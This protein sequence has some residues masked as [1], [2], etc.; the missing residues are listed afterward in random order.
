M[1][2]IETATIGPSIMIFN[3]LSHYLVR[4]SSATVLSEE[5]SEYWKYVADTG[6]IILF[7]H[8]LFVIIWDIFLTG[9]F[10]KLLFFFLS[11][12]KAF[13]AILSHT[14]YLLQFFYPFFLSVWPL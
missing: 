9:N 1:K 5:L 13:H 11:L 14:A 12:N 10:N 2:A 6:I 4:V 3:D 8:M 7:R